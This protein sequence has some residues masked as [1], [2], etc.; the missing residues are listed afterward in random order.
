[1]R[2]ENLTNSLPKLNTKTVFTKLSEKSN[3]FENI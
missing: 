2:L 1:M 3:D